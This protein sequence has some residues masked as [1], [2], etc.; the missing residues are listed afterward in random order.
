[1]KYKGRY[2]RFI[3]AV[4]VLSML[5]TPVFGETEPTFDPGNESETVVTFGCFTTDATDSLIFSIKMIRVFIQ[6]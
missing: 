5:I 3:T 4:L 1:M 2:I 6:G